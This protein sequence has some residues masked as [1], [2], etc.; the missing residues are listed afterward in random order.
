MGINIVL[1]VGEVVGYDVEYVKMLVNFGKIKE[2]VVG[3][4]GR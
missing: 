3:W 4:V 1:G 2:G